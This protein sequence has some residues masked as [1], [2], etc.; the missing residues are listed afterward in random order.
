MVDD[1]MGVAC[2]NSITLRMVRFGSFPVIECI[3]Q[4]QAAYGQK[5]PLAISKEPLR[6]PNR[7]H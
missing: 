1:S 5:R 6:E 4:P 2:R 3:K 7:L